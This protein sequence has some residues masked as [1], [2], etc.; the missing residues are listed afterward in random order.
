[1]VN[2]SA[3]GTERGEEAESQRMPKF[4]SAAAVAVVA[5]DRTDKYC[6]NPVPLRA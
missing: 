3:S 5:A 4:W 2:A 1:M 6:P